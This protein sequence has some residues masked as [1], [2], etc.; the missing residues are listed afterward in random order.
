MLLTGSLASIPTGS[1]AD[2][3]LPELWP[4]LATV[5]RPPGVCP[6]NLAEMASQRQCPATKSAEDFSGRVASGLKVAK[7]RRCKR[8][9]SLCSSAVD[10]DVCCATCCVVLLCVVSCCITVCSY[11]LDY[12]LPGVVSKSRRR[13][14]RLERLKQRARMGWAELYSVSRFSLSGRG[15]GGNYEFTTSLFSV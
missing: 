1:V 3:I 10:C 15:K 5:L 12:V 13:L 6:L 14:Q 8:G 2:A 7:S 9:T 4:F 11:V